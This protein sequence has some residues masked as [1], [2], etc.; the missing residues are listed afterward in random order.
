MPDQRTLHRIRQF[1]GT[2]RQRQHST[3][4][5]YLDEQ[6]LQKEFGISH[7]YSLTETQRKRLM[8]FEAFSQ[9]GKGLEAKLPDQKF[10]Y[11]M[12]ALMNVVNFSSWKREY[13]NEDDYFQEILRTFKRKKGWI[14]LEKHARGPFKPPRGITFWTSL[15]LQ[16]EDLFSRA[17]QLGLPN[18]WVAKRVLLLRYKVSH[19]AN[20]HVVRIPTV[21][22]A[23]TSEIFHPTQE[24][25]HPSHGIAIDI[26][27]TTN[28]HAGAPEF[29]L[30]NLRIEHIEM[31]PVMA[32]IEL[33][34]THKCYLDTKL[35]LSLHAYY[36]TL[37]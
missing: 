24:A 36:Q 27:D 3:T 37:V 22:D 17:Y 35:R 31:Y 2:K 25:N 33:S 10:L 14:P 20:S 15:P 18:N 26:S 6:V 32:G 23:F 11:R 7:P 34:G 19:L 28:L 1:I 5:A 12:S 9:G 30:S 16:P 4:L 8:E 13:P 21:L 29:V